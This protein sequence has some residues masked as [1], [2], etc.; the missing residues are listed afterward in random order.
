MARDYGYKILE[1]KSCVIFDKVEG[2]F[3]DYINS[4]YAKKLKSENEKNDIQRLIY[5]LLLNSLYGRL[6]IKGNIND[7]K[8][9][10][11]K[12][13]GK[14]ISKV[15][16][17]EKSDIL[18]QAN[19]LFLVKSEGP[20]D[21]EIFN[22]ISKEK[23]YKDENSGFH[24][25]NPWKGISS[26][27]QFSAAI[28]AYARMH[29]NK[30]KNIPGNDYLGGDTDSI[31]LTHPLFEK[32]VGSS[33]GLF[34]LEHIIVEGFY[35]QKKFYML[36]TKD[37]KIIIKAKGISNKLLNYNTFLELFKGKTIKFPMEVFMKDYKTLEVKIIET[38]KEIKGL[39]NTEIN[40]KIKNRSIGYRK[41]L[42]IIPYIKPYLSFAK[43]LTIF[44]E[45]VSTPDLHPVASRLPATTCLTT[46]ATATAPAIATAT[47][48]AIATATAIDTAKH[49]ASTTAT[50][51]PYLLFLF[52]LLALLVFIS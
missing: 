11:D 20:L 35:L 4:I 25:K 24:C 40:Y 36:V 15:L 10:K 47:A 14:K 30:F 44:K 38:K 46:P 39:Q 31:I 32:Y 6:G 16:D 9:I 34:K 27:V 37:N 28:T 29:L 2:I 48:I 21:P 22:L 42:N 51:P 41:D 23:L 17:T 43:Q 1:V 33:L 18:Y 12:P 19:D 49:P 45:Y 7:L 13:Q 5:K 52:L 3:D 50:D 8:I 26:S